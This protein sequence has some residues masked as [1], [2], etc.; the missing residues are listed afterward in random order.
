MPPT[1]KAMNFSSRQRTTALVS[2][3]LIT[4]LIACWVS[5]AFANQPAADA[6]ADPAAAAPSAPGEAPTAVL[7]D[8]TKV[9][10]VIAT[11]P[12]A[13]ATVTW[14]KAKLGRI[15]PRQPLVLVRDRDSGPLDVV[16]R[17]PGYLPVQTRAHTFSD[18]RVFVKLTPI[19]MKSTLLGYR[20]PLDA[21]IGMGDGGVPETLTGM[22]PSLTGPTLAPPGVPAQPGQLPV[23]PAPQ[24]QPQPQPQAPP[25]LQPAPVQPQP[26]PAPQPPAA[27]APAAP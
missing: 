16:V 6:A 23:Q 9:Q 25:A 26:A 18:A 21:G 4:V 19:S 20:A 14:G 2:T 10:I 1:F 11:T 5:G 12:P 22:P 3:A 7:A 27:P 17:A 13:N 24:P 8:P 15:K